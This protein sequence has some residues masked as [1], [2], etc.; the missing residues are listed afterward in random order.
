SDYVWWPTSEF[1]DLEGVFNPLRHDFEICI[2]R[3]AILSG[4][5]S[6]SAHSFVCNM[7]V[8]IANVDATSTLKK[9]RFVMFVEM[10]LKCH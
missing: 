3:S 2:H 1:A 4:G 6:Y 10:F 7:L 8:L 9:S 5:K